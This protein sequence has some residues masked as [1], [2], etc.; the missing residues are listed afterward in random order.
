L[1]QDILHDAVPAHILAAR[2]GRMCKVAGTGE[3]R[4]SDPAHTRIPLYR[5]PSVISRARM[6]GAQLQ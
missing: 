5:I 3:R 6:E 4:R 1:A 2:A